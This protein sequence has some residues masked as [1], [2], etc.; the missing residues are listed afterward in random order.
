MRTWINRK[1]RNL[2]LNATSQRIE[3]L[4][5]LHHIVEQLHSHS[6]FI[7]LSRKYIYRIPAHPKYATMKIQLITLILHRNK[8][9]QN[10]PLAH[11]VTRSQRHYHAVIIARITY[12]VDCGNGCHNNDIAPFEQTL[13]RR[14]SHLFDMLIY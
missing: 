11:F 3:K 8:P 5:T 6:Q 10:I 14:Q 4:Q 2:L 13:C 1:A 12:A 9:Q 7:V